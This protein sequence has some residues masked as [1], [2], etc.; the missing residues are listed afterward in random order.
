MFTF[1]GQPVAELASSES[2]TLADGENH[3]IGLRYLKTDNKWSLIIDGKTKAEGVLQEVAA[4]PA[5]D[6][7]ADLS[8]KFRIGINCGSGADT[9]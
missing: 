8:E 5:G 1:T 2:T 9:A 7:D 6:A 3:V 4:A